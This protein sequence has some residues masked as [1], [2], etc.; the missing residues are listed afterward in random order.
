VR[1]E[2]LDGHGVPS[3]C[4]AVQSYLFRFTGPYHLALTAPALALGFGIVSAGIYGWIVLGVLIVAG[5][6]P[7]CCATER[8]PPSDNALLAQA[9]R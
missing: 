4:T 1:R 6:T 8:L 2:H 3:E 5:S 7:I 9:C